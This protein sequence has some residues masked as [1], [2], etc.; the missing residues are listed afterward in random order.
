MAQDVYLNLI[1]ALI[2]TQYS[3]ISFA[4]AYTRQFDSGRLYASAR[5]KEDN[6]QKLYLCIFELA[7]DKTAAVRE[8]WHMKTMFDT[9]YNRPLDEDFLGLEVAVTSNEQFVVVKV[10]GSANLIR[11]GC[12]DKLSHE[13]FLEDLTRGMIDFS[14]SH[15]D[16][17]DGVVVTDSSGTR[18]EFTI[19]N[20]QWSYAGAQG[21]FVT[22][23]KEPTSNIISVTHTVS[24]LNE[25]G[26]TSEVKD[27]VAIA[28]PQALIDQYDY[29]TPENQFALWQR[30]LS[31]LPSVPDLSKPT[32]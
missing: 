17:S 8:I 12:G 4:D 25:D 13:L 27:E 20:K 16:T 14:A 7:D 24:K 2:P 29:M 31:A 21:K 22:G 28:L 26:T 18:H 30:M 9:G 5:I 32:E 3:L 1:G 6:K 15:I 19:L 23:V 11:V 10:G